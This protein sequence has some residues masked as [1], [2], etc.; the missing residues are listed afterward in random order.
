MSGLF[1]FSKLS[2]LPLLLI[3]N[4]SSLICFSYNCLYFSFSCLYFFNFSN[5]FLEVCKLL[6]N[7]SNLFPS[8]VRFFRF[9]IFE[10]FLQSYH[11][12]LV[13]SLQQV[14]LL[15]SRLEKLQLC[16]FVLVP[17]HLTL[18]FELAVS[19]RLRVFMLEQPLHQIL[20]QFDRL[21]EIR[22]LLLIQL[23]RRHDLFENLL[24]RLVR[25]MRCFCNF[26]TFLTDKLFANLRRI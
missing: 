11:L 14:I 9:R 15:K 1:C 5:C 12:I 18:L 6:P 17:Q 25:E 7:S 3:F 24:L 22:N 4:F 10:F 20:L 13:L 19:A 21:L 26:L 23:Q 2:Q 8:S 16:I